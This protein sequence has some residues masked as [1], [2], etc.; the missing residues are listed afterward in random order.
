M[1][2]CQNCNSN[3]AMVHITNIINGTPYEL[4]LCQKCAD[5]KG[6][7]HKTQFSIFDIIG[8]TLKEN[9]EKAIKERDEE[10]EDLKCSSCGLSYKEFRTR[11]RLGCSHDYE[12]FRKELLP[13][14]KRIHGAEAH[15]GKVPVTNKPSLEKVRTLR[16][17][18]KELTAAINEEDYER[19][20]KLRDKIKH[21]EESKN[22]LQ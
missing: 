12:A 17:L 19:A 3:P 15:V 11:A 8:S 14:M 5:E 4:H 2:T 1:I 20:A 9:L 18:K 6:V 22:G 7:L 13:L 10:H 16:E 21:L